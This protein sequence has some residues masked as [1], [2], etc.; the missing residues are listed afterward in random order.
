MISDPPTGVE[1]LVSAAPINATSS[2]GTTLNNNV[3]TTKRHTTLPSDPRVRPHERP[4]ASNAPLSD[5]STT[6]GV[7]TPYAA[8]TQMHSQAP[9]P[10]PATRTSVPTVPAPVSIGPPTA[11]ATPTTALNSPSRGPF[12]SPTTNSGQIFD[13]PRPIACP[14]RVGRSRHETRTSPIV[15]AVSINVPMMYVT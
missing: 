3:A 9:M 14:N 2:W 13:R 1:T 4:N 8:A 12:P 11:S 7:V 5:S 10:P 6:T 15:P